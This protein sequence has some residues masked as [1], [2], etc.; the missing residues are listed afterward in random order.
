MWDH[1]NGHEFITCF[2][3]SQ[4]TIQYSNYST[5]EMKKK[6][7]QKDGEIAQERVHGESGDKRI[8]STVDDQL[9]DLVH[10]TVTHNVGHTLMNK[11]LETSLRHEQGHGPA[12]YNLFSIFNISATS[13][14]Q[15]TSNS[16]IS[17]SSSTSISSN[18]TKE[19]FVCIAISDAPS[20][21]IS[22]A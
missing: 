21:P 7:K 22:E 9:M 20:Q 6:D 14:S 18:F 8:V 16:C 15:T 17:N 1:K 13:P 11:L 5:D 2:N 4:R 19:Q 12:S 3:L 10:R